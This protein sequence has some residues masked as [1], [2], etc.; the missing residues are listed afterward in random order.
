MRRVLPLL[1]LV[2]AGCGG[3]SVI[4]PPPPADADRAA[5][6]V[7]L[8]HIQDGKVDVAWNGTSAEFKSFMGKADFQKYVKE[9][10][11]LRQPTEPGDV[12]T[13]NDTIPLAH[14]KYRATAAKPAT[15]TVTLGREGD[16]WK[17]S[18]LKVE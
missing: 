3:K 11:Q 10:P 12:T 16:Q 4:P 8:K 7:F 1:V 5:A 2:L 6:G 17:V 9:H 14:C 13:T 18:G 15:I